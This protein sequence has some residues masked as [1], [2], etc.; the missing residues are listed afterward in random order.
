[1]PQGVSHTPDSEVA[2]RPRILELANSLA[3]AGYP[4]M[5]DLGPGAKPP[6]PTP[7]IGTAVQPSGAAFADETKICEQTASAAHG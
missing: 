7:C 5:S 1:M 3:V 4:G 6:P 2:A